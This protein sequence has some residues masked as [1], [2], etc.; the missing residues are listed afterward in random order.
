[1]SNLLQSFKQTLKNWYIPMIIG[2]CLIL[3]GIYLFTIPLKTYSAIAF[4]FALSFLVSGILSSIF[5]L[6]NRQAIN[7]WGW[8]L[9]DGIFS[10]IIGVYLLAYPKFT[11]EI[12]PFVIGFML[13]F[14]SILLVGFSFDLKD[15]RISNWTNTLIVGVLGVILSILLLTQPVFT[16]L[17]L[18]LITSCSFILIGIGSVSLSLSLRKIKKISSYLSEDDVRKIRNMQQEIDQIMDIVKHDRM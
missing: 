2:I 12:L 18:I 10:L 11:M 6:R 17:S 1:M 7:G 8:Y 5:A 3:F 14:K 9:I 15:L 4:L 13:M 16:S